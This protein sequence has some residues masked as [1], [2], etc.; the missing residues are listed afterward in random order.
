MKLHHTS[1]ASDHVCERG[2]PEKATYKHVFG[3]GFLFLLIHPKSRTQ[4]WMSLLLHFLIWFPSGALT[5]LSFHAALWPENLHQVSFFFFLSHDLRK[6]NL[7]VKKQASFVTVLSN[8]LASLRTGT[9]VSCLTW[10]HSDY[11]HLSIH[12]PL[13]SPQE[14][15]FSPTLTNKTGTMHKR[16]KKNIVRLVESNPLS[17]SK[18]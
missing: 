8:R 4:W 18:A 12:I 16:K 7:S 2:G 13:S 6:D 1:L 15:L 5:G 9:A 17:L 11:I 10:Q 3:G 14:T